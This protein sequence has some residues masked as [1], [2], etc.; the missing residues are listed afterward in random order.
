MYVLDYKITLL[1]PTIITSYSSDENMVRTLDYI[2]GSSILGLFASK[3][4]RQ[5]RIT[6]AHEDETF[7]NWFLRGD[8]NFLNGYVLIEDRY[9]TVDTLPIPLFIQKEKTGDKI[10]NILLYNSKKQ[11]MKSLN[12]Y[13]HFDC[14]LIKRLE[15]KKRINFHHARSSRLKG[16][17]DDGDIFNYEYLVPDQ[18]FKGHIYGDKEV[19]LRFK[20]MFGTRI[21][22]RLGRSKGAEYGQVEIELMDIYELEFDKGALNN[23][24]WEKEKGIFITFISPCIIL[25]GFGTSDP[26][27]YN[28]KCHLEKAFG[29]DAEF[30]IEGSKIKPIFIENYL[31]VWNMKRP[32]EQAIDCGSTIKLKFNDSVEYEDAIKVLSRLEEK[33]LGE[34]KNEGFGQIKINIAPYDEYYEDNDKI[35]IRKPMSSM[36]DIVKE[37]FKSAIIDKIM[38]KTKMEVL[39]TINNYSTYPK[40]TLLGRLGLILNT[41]RLE[42]FIFEVKNLNTPAKDQ[43]KACIYSDRHVNKSLYQIFTGDNTKIIDEILGNMDDCYEHLMKEVEFNRLDEEDELKDKIYRTYYMTLIDQMRQKNK[44]EEV[45]KIE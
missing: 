27:L 14:T 34:R 36:P 13:G 20:D 42:E 28:L 40:N 23:C 19:L 18:L 26:S 39:L 31:A 17:S 22:G 45:Q 29:D 41:S 10:L 4:I 11:Q 33:G 1:S 3:Y 35:K 25:N 43:L 8:I 6:D 21:P 37:I 16:A 9:G 12:G 2:P 44:K 30:T 15:P 32:M 24:L 38:E 5:Q 7:Y